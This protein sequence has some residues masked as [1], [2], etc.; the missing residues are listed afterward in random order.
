MKTLSSSLACLACVATLLGA[1]ACGNDPPPANP[2]TTTSAPANA[3]PAA[4]ATPPAPPAAP[5]ATLVAPAP[6]ASAAASAAECR[7]K[8]G[9]VELN[10][11]WTNDRATGTL[12]VDGK[13]Q[14]VVALLYKG[15]I[16]VDVAGTKAITGKVAT[17]TNEGKKTI[18]LGDYKQ[19]SLDCN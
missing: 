11:T 17:V 14:P 18:R 5:A 2:G 15:L 13:S 12:G 10:L 6:T 7:A 4:S 1:S 16:L 9:S 19:P 3:E 8:N